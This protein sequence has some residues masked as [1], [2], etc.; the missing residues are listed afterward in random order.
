MRVVRAAAFEVLDQ[1]QL[2]NTCT[3]S[4]TGPPRAASSPAFARRSIET[5]PAASAVM[6][7]PHFE[8]LGDRSVTAS[9]TE[10]PSW[11]ALSKPYILKTPRTRS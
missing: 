6:M 7:D 10:L 5:L 9:A 4:S 11:N 8:P 3:G 2:P 1:L